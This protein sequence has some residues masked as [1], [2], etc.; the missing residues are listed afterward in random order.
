MHPNYERNTL[1]ASTNFEVSTG[2]LE[3]SKIKNDEA[4]MSS[5]C[6]LDNVLKF[7]AREWLA[8]IVWVL[9]RR[10]ETRFGELQRA[11]P[12]Q[13]S[14]RVLS[15][16]LKQLAELG[17]VVR[18][19]IGTVPPHVEY[20]LTQEGR[21][22]DALLVEIERLANEARLPGVLNRLAYEKD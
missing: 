15:N 7:L 19:D 18:R 8:H 22:I 14:A 20:S 4:P 12:G 17:L 2:F 3:V 10:G 16:R 13:V 6:P 5:G 11:L 9:G 1:F 21:L